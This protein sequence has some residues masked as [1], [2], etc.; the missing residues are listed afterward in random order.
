MSVEILP[1]ATSVP[2]GRPLTLS[3]PRLPRWAHLR[4][5]RAID[6]PVA[7]GPPASSSIG[8]LGSV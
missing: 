1:R 8:S 7:R 4:V 3:R 6:E 2:A 5:F